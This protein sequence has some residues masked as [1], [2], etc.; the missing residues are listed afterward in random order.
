M[1]KKDSFVCFL[2][3]FVLAIFS[4]GCAMDKLKSDCMKFDKG[5]T[6]ACNR[7]CPPKCTQLA[8]SSKRVN[9]P[10]NKIQELCTQSCV[11]NCQAQLQKVRPAQCK[12]K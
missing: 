5:F 7:D 8:V 12:G 6:E 4:S 11:T 9:L 3:T 2:L 10:V 1:T